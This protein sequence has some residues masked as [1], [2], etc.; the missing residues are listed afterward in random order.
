MS[1]WPG[2]AGYRGSAQK[3]CV[4]FFIIKSHNFCGKKHAA[5]DTKNAYVQMHKMT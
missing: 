2:S 3:K 4:Y 5:D 1:S